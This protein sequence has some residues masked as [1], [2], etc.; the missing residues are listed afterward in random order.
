MA[1]LG[2]F[3]EFRRRFG[4]FGS[5]L[6]RAT[7]PTTMYPVEANEL[8]YRFVVEKPIRLAKWDM[9]CRSTMQTGST[10]VTIPGVY[11]HS[12]KEVVTLLLAE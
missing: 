2:T 7:L 3:N 4:Y 8:K 5:Q 6:A 9:E 11:N 12:R 10:L 1:V